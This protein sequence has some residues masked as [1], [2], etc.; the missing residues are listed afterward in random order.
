MRL[1]NATLGTQ[2]KNILNILIVLTLL[3]STPESSAEEMELWLG[4]VEYAQLRDAINQHGE[5]EII[6]EWL[7]HRYIPLEPINMESLSTSNN[8]IKAT[9][10]DGEYFVTTIRSQEIPRELAE[11]LVI[12]ANKEHS[13]V[14]RYAERVFTGE[15]NGKNAVFIGGGKGGMYTNSI[16]SE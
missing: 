15:L 7:T 2:M 4:K 3:S 10:T 6:I 1:L 9:P 12:K 16:V 13:T 11:N 14:V 5:P 8:P